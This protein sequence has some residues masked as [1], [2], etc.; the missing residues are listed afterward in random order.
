ML[1]PTTL[2]TV[3]LILF[4]SVNAHIKLNK[5]VLYGK[6]TLNN[7]PLNNTG[8][9][10]PCNIIGGCPSNITGNLIANINGNGAAVFQYTLP[11]GM[12]NNQYTL[13][14]TW[15]N[16]V[17]NREIYINCTLITVTSGGNDNL[18]IE[19][20]LNIFVANIPFKTYNIPE[21]F[22]YQF[23]NPADIS[24]SL[25]RNCASITKI[26]ARVG[27]LGSASGVTSSATASALAATSAISTPT[28]TSNLGTPGTSFVATAPISF[29]TLTVT[30]TA[31]A[32]IGGTSISIT[33]TASSIC[34]P[35]SNDGAII[36]I[37][38]TQFGFYLTTGITYLNGIISKRSIV[39]RILPH[40]I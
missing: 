14:W 1:A 30:N 2:A 3:A 28:A 17:G 38:T 9:D 15:F 24:T 11:K 8:D 33:P 5:P 23:P 25:S 7:N 4:A 13:G 37:S 21:N 6:D 40:R 32:L 12:L 18:V 36:Y 22:N 26:G 27:T 10:F 35:Y 29:I 19:K 31:T 20:L 39:R 16:K 34:F